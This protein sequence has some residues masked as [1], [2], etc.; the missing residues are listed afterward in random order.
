[1]LELGAL[2]CADLRAKSVRSRPPPTVG[3]MADFK[4]IGS[5][6]LKVLDQAAQKLPKPLQK[7]LEDASKA[8]GQPQ[9]VILGAV[10]AFALL[11]IWILLPADLMLHMVG[12]GYPLFVSLKM[13]ATG[14]TEDAKFWLAY[15]VIFAGFWL[16]D[17][18][19]G[20]ILN[21]I[22]FVLYVKCGALVYLYAPMTRGVDK[23]IAQVFEPFVYPHLGG[24]PY[25]KKTAPPTET[26]VNAE[27]QKEMEKLLTEDNN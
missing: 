15:W 8:A 27:A 24:K 2:S 7:H 3:F 14:K 22:P 19:F 4:K 23:V 6:L 20:W 13:L 16:V 18:F 26:K 10:A 11:L 17:F 25:A 9:G 21:I 1:V 5:T 12:A